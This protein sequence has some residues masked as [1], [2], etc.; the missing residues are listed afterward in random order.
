LALDRFLKS[1]K[2]LPFYEFHLVVPVRKQKITAVRGD[3]LN[4]TR[5]MHGASCG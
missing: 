2:L 4:N 1:S 5:R 3:F